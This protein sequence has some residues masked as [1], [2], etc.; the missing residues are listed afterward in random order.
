MRGTDLQDPGAA[1]PDEGVGGDD[2]GPDEDNEHTEAF[3]LLVEEG[4]ARL[5]RSWSNLLATGFIAGFDVGLGVLALLFVE[6]ETGSILLGALAFPIGFVAL[7]VGRSELFTENFMVPIAT[8]VARSGT[9]RQLARLWCFTY[10][11]NL[12]GGWCV[13]VL[14]VLAYPALEPT[15]LQVASEIE[16]R[17]LS[18]EA[19]ALAILAG[20]AITLMTWMQTN[21]AS[22]GGRL[23]AVVLIAFLLAAAHMNHV[24]VISIKLFAALQFGAPFGYGDWLAISS[25]S[26][27][28]NMTGGIGLV[29]VLRLL[30]V[31]GVHIRR[32]QRTA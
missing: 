4:A 16:G 29:T 30:Q 6:H 18:T 14:T 22:D 10:V 28:G 27:L 25:M 17:H 5:S 24:V 7:A 8:V 20:A 1:G 32:R 2:T 11:M 13:A 9:W 26:A 31:G 15:V 19:F 21:A 3:D 12:A 23:T